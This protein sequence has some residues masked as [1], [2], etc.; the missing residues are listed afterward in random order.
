MNQYRCETCGYF[1]ET[2]LR[3]K[4]YKFH[5][6]EESVCTL[7]RVGCASH[8]SYQSEREKVLDELEKY[9]ESFNYHLYPEEMLAKIEELRHK[10]GE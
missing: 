2:I 8:S 1:L 7:T 4:R 5:L 6:P 3:C 9:T 10:K